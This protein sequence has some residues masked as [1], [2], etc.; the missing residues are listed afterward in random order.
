MA[1]LVDPAH[2]FMFEPLRYFDSDSSGIHP[3]RV[4]PTIGAARDPACLDALKNT[5]SFIS[6][7]APA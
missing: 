3:S 4:S 7:N 5:A 6:K 2:D 1:G